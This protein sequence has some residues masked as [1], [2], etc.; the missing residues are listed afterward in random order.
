MS[1]VLFREAALADGRS[2]HLRVGV[3]A[4]VEDR[5]LAWIRPTDDEGDLGR[6]DDLEVVDASGGTIVPGM[7]DG[8]SHVTLPGGAHWIDRIDDGP[9]ALL[10]AADLNGGLLTASG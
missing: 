2:D 8:H 1:R 4:L 6:T 10:R 5:R 7:V 9:D 3:S